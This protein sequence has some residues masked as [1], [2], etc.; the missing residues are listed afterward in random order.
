M[1]IYRVKD[2]KLY[3]VDVKDNVGEEAFINKQAGTGIEFLRLDSTMLP[4]VDDD[5]FISDHYYMLDGDGNVIVDEERTTIAWMK[6][7]R[8]KLSSYIYSK[9]SQTKQNSDLADKIYYETVLKAKGYSD[10]EQQLVNSVIAFL[11]GDSIDKILDD[12]D[13]P[14]E[15]RMSVTQLLKL[16]IRVTWVQRCKGELYTA[17]AD[18]REP[19]Y[20]EY[21]I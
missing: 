20:M 15:D 4:L 17:I 7:E 14:D 8:V 19:D 1:M 10:L 2:K 16:G 12:N 11:G 18:N 13:V 3:R 5:R 6:L 21:P 9:Y